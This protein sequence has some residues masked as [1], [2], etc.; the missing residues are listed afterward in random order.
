MKDVIPVNVNEFDIF[1]YVVL[2]HLNLC[3]D[4]ISKEMRQLI[5]RH[6]FVDGIVRDYINKII[7]IK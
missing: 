4:I 2:T 7:E 5:Y 3:G 6:N 1:L